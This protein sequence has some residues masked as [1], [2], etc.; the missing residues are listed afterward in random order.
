[1][2]VPS[3]YGLTGDAYVRSLIDSGFLGTLA[4]STFI[5]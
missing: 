2:I 3:P 4:K 1:M 5:R